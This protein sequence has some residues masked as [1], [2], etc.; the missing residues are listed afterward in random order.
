MMETSQ[1][2]YVAQHD[3][4]KSKIMMKADMVGPQKEK[5]KRSTSFLARLRSKS[6][7]GATLTE[8]PVLSRKS[9]VVHLLSRRFSSPNMKKNQ[10]VYDEVDFKFITSWKGECGNCSGSGLD[11]LGLKCSCQTEIELLKQV[12]KADVL[13]FLTGELMKENEPYK[14]HYSVS[15]L[16]QRMSLTETA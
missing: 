9:S 3:N 13:K 4:G 6:A 8:A 10:V 7:R 14:G 16:H 1:I 5:L 2:K 11:F 12:G 15:N